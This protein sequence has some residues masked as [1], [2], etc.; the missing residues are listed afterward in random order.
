MAPIGFDPAALATVV[1]V[2]G[3]SYR[4]S[5]ARM[6]LTADGWAAGGV[7]GGLQGGQGAG[8][9]H[10]EGHHHR[11]AGGQ[12]LQAGAHH[13]RN[14]APVGQAGGA[15]GGGRAAAHGEEFLGRREAIG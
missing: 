13:L 9:Q 8:G 3:S 15:L 4:R 11:I 7:S 2:S 12:A 6:L 14:V 1:A 5:G 10:G